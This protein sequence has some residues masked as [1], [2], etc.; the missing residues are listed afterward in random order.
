MGPSPPLVAYLRLAVQIIWLVVAAFAD[1]QA[2][3]RFGLLVLGL[4]DP[5]HVESVAV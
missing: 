1:K 2:E 5:G 4:G 3:V